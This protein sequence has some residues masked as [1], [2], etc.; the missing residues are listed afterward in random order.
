[1]NEYIITMTGKTRKKLLKIPTPWNERIELTI[2]QLKTQPFMGE[3]MFG[4]LKD[5]RKIRVWP[6]RI[7]YSIDENTKEIRISEI[8]HRG[9]MSYK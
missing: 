7:I 9:N 1:M 5:K 8:N 4:E 2:D 6:Y 3:K